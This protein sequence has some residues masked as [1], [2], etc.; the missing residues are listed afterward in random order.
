VPISLDPLDPASG[1]VLGRP[2]LADGGVVPDILQPN[3]C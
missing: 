3:G 1:V 2:R